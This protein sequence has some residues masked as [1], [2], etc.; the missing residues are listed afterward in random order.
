MMRW[1]ITVGLLL[2]GVA[3]AGAQQQYVCTKE[4]GKKVRVTD[5]RMAGPAPTATP[6]PV[7]TSSPSPTQSFD[8]SGGTFVKSTPTS[9][10][11]VNRV[12]PYEQVTN[13][14]ATVP[15]GHMFLFLSS[16]NHSNASC[17]VMHITMTS[18]SGKKYESESVQP[19]LAAAA[20]AG[21]WSIVA[22]LKTDAACAKNAPFDFYLQWQ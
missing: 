17:N 1:R 2:F 8:C 21:K 16:V 9:V 3:S 13:L 22:T 18:P 7:S 15:T 6:A 20:E 4:N 14:C 19:G 10:Q 5:C 12:Y 11:W